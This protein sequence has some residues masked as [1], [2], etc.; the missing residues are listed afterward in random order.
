M[1]HVVPVDWTLVPSYGVEN[2]VRT[3]RRRADELARIG[4]GTTCIVANQRAVEV[5]DGPPCPG[6]AHPG[7]ASVPTPVDDAG[8]VV[9]L[10][11][12][13]ERGPGRAHLYSV[14]D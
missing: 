9:S 14:E 3:H 13:L 6:F 5:E 4:P 1:F 7:G 8:G 2:T 11:V 12:D 10:A